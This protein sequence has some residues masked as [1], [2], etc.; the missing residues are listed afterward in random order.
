MNLYIDQRLWCSLSNFIFLAMKKLA[1]LP[2][3][4]QVLL[5]PIILPSS[6]KIWDSMLCHSDYIMLRYE[7]KS[8]SKGKAGMLISLPAKNFK[9]S[10]IA[11][12]RFTFSKNYSQTLI[13][14]TQNLK[15][16][17]KLII[18]FPIALYLA[19]WMLWLLS[20]WSRSELLYYSFWN[21]GSRNH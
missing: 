1:G 9:K 5:T 10:L 18:E 14:R 19:N 21:S 20:E 15:P 11:S 4:I 7:L 8:N 16:K 3:D 2:V 13:I 12:C 6:L 17:F